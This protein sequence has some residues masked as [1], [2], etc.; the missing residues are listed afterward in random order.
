[1]LY[2]TLP[3]K[4]HNTRHNTAVCVTSAKNKSA[5]M[6]VKSAGSTKCANAHTNEC[7]S[8]HSKGVDK[9]Q[10][11]EQVAQNGTFV[12]A[13]GLYVLVPV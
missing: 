6:S 3:L 1:M 10:Q 7:M 11:E 2:N 9:V 13:D 12:N 5:C 4:R 8:S